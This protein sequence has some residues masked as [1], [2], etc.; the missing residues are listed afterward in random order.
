MHVLYLSVSSL[1]SL[2]LGF[3]LMDDMVAM[4]SSY[5][6]GNQFIKP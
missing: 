1:I 4:E 6:I 5:K 2:L 3:K